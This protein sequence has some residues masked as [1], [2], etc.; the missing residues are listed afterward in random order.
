MDAITR[1]GGADEIPSLFPAAGATPAAPAAPGFAA[2]L[3]GAL[4][5]LL[6]AQRASEKATLELAAGRTEDLHEV[7]LSVNQA[8]LAMQLALEVRNRLVDAYHEV[9]RMTV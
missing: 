8:G 7:M 3:D 9:M 2:A 4:G 5:S 6:D 1:I